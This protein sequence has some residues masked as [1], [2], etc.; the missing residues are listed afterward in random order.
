M[1]HHFFESFLLNLPELLNSPFIILEIKIQCNIDR[2]LDYSMET[3]L[4]FNSLKVNIIQLKLHLS[5]GSNKEII[6]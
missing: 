3:Y 6:D 2:L 5:S 1:Y 4:I